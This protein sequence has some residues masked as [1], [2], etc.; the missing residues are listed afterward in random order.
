MTWMNDEEFGRQTLAGIN[1]VVIKRAT[2]S[3]LSPLLLL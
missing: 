2:V 3:L 1:P